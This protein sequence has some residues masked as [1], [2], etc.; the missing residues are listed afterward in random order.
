MAAAG[1]LG[2]RAASLHHDIKLCVASCAFMNVQ[3]ILYIYIY[4]CVCVPNLKV[5]RCLSR[6]ADLDWD[7]S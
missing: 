4:V 6:I 5:I 7:I 2:S 3:Y 1:F